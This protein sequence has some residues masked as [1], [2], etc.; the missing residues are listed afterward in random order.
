MTPWRLNLKFRSSNFVPEAFSKNP[1]RSCCI[2]VRVAELYPCFAGKLGWTH[3]R[4]DL[5]RVE[6]ED[7]LARRV[8]FWCAM[9]FV[10]LSLFPFFFFFDGWHDVEMNLNLAHHSIVTSMPSISLYSLFLVSKFT[11]S[12]VD[13]FLGFPSHLHRYAFSCAS[14][15]LLPI[16]L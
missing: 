7:R 2:V 4:E 16:D 1:T 6:E 10:N 13:Q 14:W 11:V 3:I 15:S 12:K 8:Y 9:L 5:G